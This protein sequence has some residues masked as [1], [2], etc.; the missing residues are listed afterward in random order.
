MNHEGSEVGGR[1]VREARG[2]D[3]GERGGERHGRRQSDHGQVAQGQRA[4]QQRRQQSPRGLQV[5]DRRGP[6]QVRSF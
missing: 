2:D 6:G 3:H 5:E 1:P 4:D